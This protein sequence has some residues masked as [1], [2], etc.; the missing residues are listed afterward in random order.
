M[1]SPGSA[2]IG[3]CGC[4]CAGPGGAGACRNRGKI[5][6]SGDLH[7]GEGLPVLRFGRCKVLVRDIDL[8]FKRIQLRVVI[9]R[10]PGATGNVVLRLCFLPS[11][12]FLVGGR[13]LN[14]GLQ[15][16]GADRTRRK[17]RKQQGNRCM[18]YELKSRHTCHFLH[19]RGGA[20]E[21]PA[22]RRSSLPR[23]SLDAALAYRSCVP[24][25]DFPFPGPAPRLFKNQSRKRS[26]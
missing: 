11:L 15:V 9:D 7:Q 3:G 1:R 19:A 14:L 23:V 12:D 8:V 25:K 13:G 26:M 10:P 4:G 22:R 24:G 21:C 16:I 20:V 5:G 2:G 18:L 6:R 17:D